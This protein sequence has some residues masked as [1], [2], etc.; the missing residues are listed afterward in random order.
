MSF[1]ASIKRFPNGIFAFGFFNPCPAIPDDVAPDVVAADPVFD[2]VDP[3]GPDGAI[4]AGQRGGRTDAGVLDVG[5]R[6]NVGKPADTGV[7]V[8]RGG[9]GVINNVEPDGIGVDDAGPDGNTG[10][11][12]GVVEYVGIPVGFIGVITL[13]E[14]P[15]NP[16]VDDPDAG[17]DLAANF[18]L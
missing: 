1:L 10:P 4:P 14:D 2:L 16:T 18:D 3:A 9:G 5:G 15:L 12:I 8:P 7:N 13:P 11:V 17:G 6:A